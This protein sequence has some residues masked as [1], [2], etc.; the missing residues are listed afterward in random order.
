MEQ[1]LA[2][3]LGPQPDHWEQDYSLAAARLLEQERPINI[4][5]KLGWSFVGRDGDR[6]LP[7]MLMLVSGAAACPVRR[8]CTVES[9]DAAPVICDI[10]SS[11]SSC[12]TIPVVY[13]Y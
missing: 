6:S 10:P 1:F 9:C 5:G 8:D 13:S 12:L 7:W 11:T 3:M 4:N 2:E